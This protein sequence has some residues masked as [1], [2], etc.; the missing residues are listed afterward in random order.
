LN[1]DPQSGYQVEKK[2]DMSNPTYLDL[3]SL[4]TTT[5]SAY[6]AKLMPYN[7]NLSLI[8]KDVLTIHTTLCSTKLTQNLGLLSLL[9]WRSEPENLRTNLTVFARELKAAEV[10]KFLPDVLDALFSIL[11][12]NSDSELY[13]N[14]VFEALIAVIE[15]V[16]ADKFKQFVPVLEVYINENYSATLAYNKL[17]VVFKAGLWIR[18]DSIRIRIQH[19]CSIWIQFRIRIQGKTELSN[20]IF[21]SNCFEIKI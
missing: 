21:V 9:K 5:S 14:L 4:K 18:I 3:P 13:D 15:M 17:L 6:K 10:V 2:F 1:P 8:T 16:T 7:N 20:T 12:E 11:M 19:F